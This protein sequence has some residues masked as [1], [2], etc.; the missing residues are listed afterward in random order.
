L[1][2]N[3]PVLSAFT[4]LLLAVVVFVVIGLSTHALTRTAGAMEYASNDIQDELQIQLSVDGF[5]PGEVQHVAGTFA[6]AVHNSN[7]P[8]E[9]TL[10]LKAGDDTVVKEVQVQ[11]GSAAWTVTLSAGEYT[12]TEASHPQWQCRI[13][14]Q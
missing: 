4:G 7:V 14:V 9:Y 13:T 3:T 1:Y 11:E 5:T 12:L 2:I 6:I 10:R 8:G